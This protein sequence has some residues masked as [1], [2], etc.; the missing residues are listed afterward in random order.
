[1]YILYSVYFQLQMELCGKI[2]YS[3]GNSRGGVI[4]LLSIWQRRSLTALPRNFQ[5]VILEDMKEKGIWTWGHVI[6]DYRGFFRNMKTLGLNKITVWN[7]YA[8]VNAKEILEEA[9]RN[10]IKVIWGFS[11]GWDTDCCRVLTDFGREKVSAIK[12]SVLKTFAAQY[13][14]IAADG[15]Y[16]QTFTELSN[17]EINGVKIADAA[18]A[19]V[20]ETAGELLLQN[21]ELNI[22]F[23]LHASGVTE[24]LDIIAKT[25]K[26]V[27]IVW[28]DLGAFPFAYKPTDTAHFRETLLLTQKVLQL[29][30][31][32]EKC[33]F[34]IKGMTTLDWPSF[35]HAEQPLVIGESSRAFIE[36]RQR[37]K[38]ALWEEL[39]EGWRSSL[40][41]AQKTFDL[42]KSY[43]NDISVQALI[44]DGM[45]ENEIKEPPK[46]FSQLCNT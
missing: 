32:D 38:D 24:D 18:V 6:Y 33:G 28:E 11:W 31:S 26:R 45:F 10:G 19:L 1:M 12:N 8:P 44:E 3:I 21:P 7:D 39:A 9:H 37:E 14:E 40:V 5:K 22:E 29:R 42:L 25:D 17:R 30:G 2:W 41:Y 23:G 4:L 15:I 20:N 27:R 13:S 35:V 43:G 36:K 16:F 34:I 46:L